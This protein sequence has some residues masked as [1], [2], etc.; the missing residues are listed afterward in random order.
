MRGRR[1]GSPSSYNAQHSEPTGDIISGIATTTRKV[2][3][4]GFYWPHILRDARKLVQG[5]DFMGPFPSSSIKKYVP[6][7]IDYVSNWVEAQ[8]FPTNDA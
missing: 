3:E 1:R 5:I 8:A 2:F 4:A 6:V 7:A